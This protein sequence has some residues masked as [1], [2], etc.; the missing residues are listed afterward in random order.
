M[1]PEVLNVPAS[2]DWLIYVNFW[3]LDS[4]LKA[5]STT[6]QKLRP[7]QGT[8]TIQATLPCCWNLWVQV[9]CSANS[10]VQVAGIDSRTYRTNWSHLKNGIFGGPYFRYSFRVSTQ[11]CTM[12]SADWPSMFSCSVLSA[13]R[14]GCSPLCRMLHETSTRSQLQL[15]NTLKSTVLKLHNDCTNYI[16]LIVILFQLSA[17]FRSCNTCSGDAWPGASSSA[18]GVNILVAESATCATGAACSCSQWM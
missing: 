16:L 5:F 15:S 2:F 12:A 4:L 17:P 3:Y 6:H 10:L 9:L 11:V 18:A 7:S 13:S 14:R 1:D 8:S